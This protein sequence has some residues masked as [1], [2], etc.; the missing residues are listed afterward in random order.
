MYKHLQGQLSKITNLPLFYPIFHWFPPT[1][2]LLGEFPTDCSPP[3]MSSLPVDSLL[4]GYRPRPVPLAAAIGLAG[5]CDPKSPFEPQPPIAFRA[6]FWPAT[7]AVSAT[8]HLQ[9]FT[10][11]RAKDNVHCPSLR[12]RGSSGPIRAHCRRWASFR[13]DSG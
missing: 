11:V 7:V 3:A 12:R 10:V 1:D 4:P 9:T 6:E 5:N 2:G 13:F 8:D